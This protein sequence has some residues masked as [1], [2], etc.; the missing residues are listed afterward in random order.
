MRQYGKTGRGHQPRIDADIDRAHHAGDVRFALGEPV[1][2]RSLARLP[3]PDQEAHIARAVGNF[4][5]VA[6]EIQILLARGEPIQRRHVVD[7]RSIRRRHDRGRPAHDVIAD[8]ADLPLRPGKGHVVGGMAGRGDSL[9]RPAVALDDVA[10]VHRDIRPE[11]AVG[12]RLRIVLFA[13][14]ARP[15]GAVRTLGIDGGAGRSLDPRG[16]RRMVAMGM[17]DENMR[18]GLAAHG[19]Q[20][21][22]RMRLAVRT[23]ID[24]RDLAPAQDIADRAAESERARIVAEHATHTRAHFLSVA[25]LEREVAVE[26]DVVVGHACSLFPSS[27]PALS[28]ASTSFFPNF[29]DVDGRDKPGHD[30]ILDSDRAEPYENAWMPVMARPRISA[31]TSWVPS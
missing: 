7:H 30:D 14:I 12:A 2:D 25:R 13:L 5:A 16:V 26:G 29:Q 1:Q 18:H 31:C 21:R 4:R 9:E 19:V 24:D 3:M 10:A 17:R 23:G 11:V 27:C 15:R 22:V 28:R 6:G 8:K 20:Q